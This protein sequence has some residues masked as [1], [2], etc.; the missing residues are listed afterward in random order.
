MPEA[1]LKNLSRWSPTQ[2]DLEA[3]GTGAICPLQ[4]AWRR[5]VG[6]VEAQQGL[7]PDA[8]YEAALHINRW[9][10]SHTPNLR[11][12]LAF[13]VGGAHRSSAWLGVSVAEAGASSGSELAHST[14]DLD[15]ALQIWK[16]YE[17]V[18][19]SGP[20]LSRTVRHLH[21]DAPQARSFVDQPVPHFVRQL[22]NLARL[23]VPRVLAIHL[24]PGFTS[25]GLREE[26]EQARQRAQRN[27]PYHPMVDFFGFTRP[28]DS[29]QAKSNRLWQEAM[30]CGV[31]IRLH[32][33]PPRSIL[34]RALEDALGED[35]QTG[36]RFR[37]EAPPLFHSRPGPMGRLLRS[38]SAGASVPRP[39]ST[40]SEDEED[41]P[42]EQ[43]PF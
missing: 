17:D 30:S 35:L 42:A 37:E 20:K 29:L 3:L 1:S 2:S 27:A 26:I 18:P 7:C 40:A 10:A 6:F 11:L 23:D 32:G 34:M 4:T 16:L 19:K 41:S 22:H 13:R 8:S 39:Y 12:T 14:A 21:I 24:R 5:H 33:P 43:I 31:R 38:M 9:L 25:V 15:E 28:P 36:V